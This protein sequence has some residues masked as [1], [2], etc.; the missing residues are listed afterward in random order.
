M[1]IDLCYK[2]HELPSSQHKAGLAGMLL[3]I[4]TMKQR[5][6]SPVPDVKDLSNSSVTISFTSDSLQALFDEF[7]DA[8]YIEVSVKSKW[9]SKKPKR[10]EEET[11]T[12]KGK[13]KTIKKFIYDDFQ[14]KASFL[15]VL[16]PPGSDDWIKLWRDMLWNILRAQPATRGAFE[17]RAQSKLFPEASKLYKKLSKDP[18]AVEDYAGSLYVG[19][20]SKNAELVPFKGSVKECLLLHFWTI[21]S[22]VFVPSILKIERSSADNKLGVKYDDHGYVLVIPEVQFLKAFNRDI[23]LV[24]SELDKTRAGYRPRDCKVDLVAEGGI[25]YLYSIV[26]SNVQPDID[27]CSVA[28]MDIFHLKKDGNNVNAY[29]VQKIHPTAKIIREYKRIKTGKTNHLF[30]KMLLGNILQDKVWYHNAQKLF[31]DYPMELFVKIRGRTPDNIFFFGDSA[32]KK[33]YSLRNEE[34]E[35][36][37]MNSVE[38]LETTLA[39]KVYDIIRNFVKIRAEKKSGHKVESF[40]RNEKGNIIYSEKYLDAVKKVCSDAFLALRG[41]RENDFIEYFT[42]TIFSVPQY[43][44]KDDYLL[45]SQKLLEDWETIKALSM[46]AISAQSSITLNKKEKGEK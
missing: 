42:G 30:K 7:Y 23:K 1:T 45:V 24:M 41:R 29:A 10:V 32:N 8:E 5:R 33:F 26:K 37:N 44:K 39:I 31:S 4:E 13:Q 46:M 34:M 21:V 16:Y 12:E 15:K 28:S 3:L 20:Q 19:A 11:V 38:G 17:G 14:P 40:E 18:D 22:R 27:D 6:I 43:M 9:G 2:L 36:E 35:E 25:D